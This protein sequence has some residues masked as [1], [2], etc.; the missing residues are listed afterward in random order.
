MLALPLFGPLSLGFL[1]SVKALAMEKGRAVQFFLATLIV[2]SLLSGFLVDKMKKNFLLMYLSALLCS[3]VSVSFLF[4]SRISDYFLVYLA[5]GFLAG[6][7]PAAVGAF[8]AEKVSPEDRGRVLSIPVGA[9]MAVAYL[10][11]LNEPQVLTKENGVMVI[12]VILACPL[13]TFLLR[14]KTVEEAKPSKSKKSAD[15]RTIMFYSAPV[16]LFY[17]TAGILF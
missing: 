7:S 11:L 17:W 6:L 1:V 5:L 8:L 4:L 15:L 9:S 3:A 12:S 10:F 16:L 13:S 14:V 2:S